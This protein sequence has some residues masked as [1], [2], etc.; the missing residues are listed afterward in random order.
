MMPTTAFSVTFAV[1]TSPA[2]FVKSKNHIPST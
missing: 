2:A 1:Y